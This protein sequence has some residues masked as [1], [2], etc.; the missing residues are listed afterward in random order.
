MKIHEGT[1][2]GVILVLSRAKFIKFLCE[3][4]N[5]KHAPLIY[6]HQYNIQRR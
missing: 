2:K 6:Q 1:K 5:V 4:P 3:H